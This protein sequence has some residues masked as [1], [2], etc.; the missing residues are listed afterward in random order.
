M[1]KASRRYYRTVLLGLAAMGVLIWAAIDQFEL[2]AQEMTELF[3][4]TL[5]VMGGTIVFAAVFATLWI[6]LRRLLR[7]RDKQ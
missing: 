7:S 1:S 2:S 3:L 4:G 6:V 5:W